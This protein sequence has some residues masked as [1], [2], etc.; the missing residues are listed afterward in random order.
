[1]QGVSVSRGTADVPGLDGRTL[2]V[3]IAA[4]DPKRAHAHEQQ[5]NTGANS[6]ANLLHRQPEG[7]RRQDHDDRQPGRRPGPARPARAGR[8]PRPARQRHDGLGHRQARARPQR[9][10]R[11]ARERDGRRGPADAVRKG[12]YDVLGA[13]RELAGAEVELVGLE[14]R[15]KRL[16]SALAAVGRR[17]RL[18]A[19]RLP[20]EP[21]PADANGLCERARRD[22]ADAVRVLRARRPVRPGQHHQAG[23]RQPQ[24][25]A[26][27]H[28][29]AAGH[30]R[31]RAS[32]CSSRSASSSRR[33][34][35]TRCS[36]P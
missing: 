6:D 17:L 23:A 12:G 28:R 7:R 36:T 5:L 31:R 4:T 22:R 10:R 19:D 11:A 9:L 25:G 29:P 13:N 16:R 35:A 8:R 18:R 3:W 14:R 2:L 33:T 30:V 32:R 1:M 21:E 26:A 15:D 27:D 34:S 24:P 20:A